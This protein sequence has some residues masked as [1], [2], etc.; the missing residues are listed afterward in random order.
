MDLNN[1]NPMQKKSAQIYSFKVSLSREMTE[2][3]DLHPDLS[4]DLSAFTLKIGHQN[5]LFSI[6]VIGLRHIP[7]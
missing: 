2:I 5:L 3:E 1:L 6:G 7:Q 4:T